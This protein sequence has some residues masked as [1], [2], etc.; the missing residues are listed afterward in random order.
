VYKE[1]Q[2]V[3]GKAAELSV[4]V[5]ESNFADETY[6][7]YIESLTSQDERQITQLVER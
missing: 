1:L 4:I 7:R 2:A 6:Y 3:A 5:G